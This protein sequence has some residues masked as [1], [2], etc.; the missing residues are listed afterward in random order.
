MLRSTVWMIFRLSGEFIERLFVAES[1]D[2]ILSRRLVSRIKRPQ[3]APQETETAGF[4]HVPETHRHLQRWSGR[5]NKLAYQRARCDSD[6]QA[7]S[8]YHSRLLQYERNDKGA[9]RPQGFENS[10]LPSPF[11]NRG[12]HGKQNY[13]KAEQHRNENH[14]KAEF[15]QTR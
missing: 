3:G 6:Q 2:R 12:V 9:R 15:L 4:Q 10:N 1:L 8:S 7:Q 11:E 14:R 5:D 13:H